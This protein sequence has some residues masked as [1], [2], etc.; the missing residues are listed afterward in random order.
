VQHFRCDRASL[1][2]PPR[3]SERSCKDA[4]GIAQAGVDLDAT[5][6]PFHRFIVAPLVNVGESQL[7]VPKGQLRIARA[8]SDC[9]DGV[10]G[11]FVG[12]PKK[13][14]YLADVVVSD[15]KIGIIWR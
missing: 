6:A 9:F 2:N 1:V 3:Q 10:F 13:D 5:P 4:I 15:G 7:V 14:F 12:A 8:Q 11:S